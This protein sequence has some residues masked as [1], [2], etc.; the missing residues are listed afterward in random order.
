MVNQQNNHCQNSVQQNVLIMRKTKYPVYIKVFGVVIYDSNVML[1]F[2]FPHS[3]RFKT[4]ANIKW[5]EEVVLPWI[6]KVAAGRPEF[7]QYDSVPCYTSKRIL[8]WVSE[9]FCDYITLNIWPPNF[10]ACKPLD[11]Y[12]WGTVRKQNSMQH[13]TENKNPNEETLKMLWRR[14]YLMLMMISWN[15]FHH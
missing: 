14:S 12:V 9:N 15:K 2:I 6:E 10:P 11:Y 4:E 13:Q 3:L 1:P 8:S 5:L 7:W